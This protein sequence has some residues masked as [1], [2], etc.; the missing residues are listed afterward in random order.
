MEIMKKLR[1]S[2]FFLVAVTIANFMLL[3]IYLIQQKWAAF[4]LTLIFW[5]CC[6]NLAYKKE[7][8]YKFIG[9]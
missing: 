9:W 5:I 6:A 8:K 2:F 7:K 4:V 3:I 1:I